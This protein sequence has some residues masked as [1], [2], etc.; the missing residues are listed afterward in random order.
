MDS[1]ALHVVLYTAPGCCLCDDLKAQLKQIGVELPLAVDEID[2][3]SDS[4][5]EAE[6]R[7][8]IP[9][10]RVQGRKMVKHRIS[11][12][13]LRQRLREAAGFGRYGLRFLR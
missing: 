7:S 5:L 13:A 9:V 2:I 10:L 6:Y 12:D 8:E 11:T 1:S 4:A 3:T